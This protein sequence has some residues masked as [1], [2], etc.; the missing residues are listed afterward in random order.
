MR[1]KLKEVCE[2]LDH[3]RVPLS[4]KEREERTR[5]KSIDELYPYY[6]ATQQAGYIDDYIFNETLILLGEDGV[7]FYD[8]TKPKAYLIS[9]KS[10]VNNHAHVLKVKEDIAV[11]NYVLYFLNVFD[12]H[13]FVSGSTRLKLNKSKMENIQILLPP[14]TQQKKI[15]HTLDKAKELIE[16]RKK[17]IAKLDALAKSLFVD[18]FGDP[19]ENPMG[20]EVD[21]L[22]NFGTW[23]GGG[24]PS[25]KEPEYF[26]GD[27]PWITTVSLGQLY[28]DSSNA[29][30]FISDKAIEK[31]STKIIP[32]ASVIIGTRVAVGKASISTEELCTNQDIVS[33]TNLKEFVIDIYLYAAIDSIKKVLKN[34]QRGATIQGITLKFLKEVILP[35]PPLPLQQKFANTIQKIESQKSLYEKELAKLEENFEALLAKSFG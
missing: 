19:V 1:V 30:E 8:R 24:T 10:W 29:V 13:G 12:Y 27:N 2:I 32:K 5:N 17:S 33:L 21:K 16:L 18:M 31:S 25:R 7:M 15:T 6:G 3:K 35:V 4:K 26:K 28:V 20:W 22:D 11:I 34:E 23:L 14:L 9:G